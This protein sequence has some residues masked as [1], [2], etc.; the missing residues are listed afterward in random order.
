[1]RA[2]V[3]KSDVMTTPLPQPVPKNLREQRVSFIA[4]AP[5]E[6]LGGY[7]RR[8]SRSALPDSDSPEPLPNR[9]SQCEVP[10]R[11]SRANAS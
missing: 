11:G 1:M 5:E 10:G 3:P 9:P 6:R 7:R 2:R 8:T 4:N